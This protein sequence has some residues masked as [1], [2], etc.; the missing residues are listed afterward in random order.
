MP[1]DIS[2]DKE[3]IDLWVEEMKV[4]HRELV[5]FGIIYWYLDEFSCVLIKRNRMWFHAAIP[6]IEET[7]NTILKERVNGYEHRAAKKR[8]RGSS[9][10][11]VETS[12]DS[13]K[14]IRN[15]PLGNHVC[16]VK[17]SS[18]EPTVPPDAPSLV[19]NC[20]RADTRIIHYNL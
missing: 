11:I 3:T 15:M 5:L 10:I 4:Q 9:E 18:G 19:Q 7:W 8:E 12:E 17:L 16:L 13:N 20:L 14:Q 1:V 6:V 2:I